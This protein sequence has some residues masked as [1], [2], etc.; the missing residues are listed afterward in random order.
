VLLTG[1]TGVSPLWDLPRVSCLIRVSLGCVG[2]GQFLTMLDVFWLALCR[3]LFPCRLRFGGVFFPGPREVI[4][5]LWNICCAAA[6]ATGL[7][8][9][10]HRSD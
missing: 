4:E 8:D 10:V 1:L 3:V 2:A 7:T 5:A 9:S 6:I